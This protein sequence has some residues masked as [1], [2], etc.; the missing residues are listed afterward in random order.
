MEFGPRALGHRSIIAA[1]DRPGV[2]RKINHAIKMRDFWMP[3]APAVLAER[4]SEYV[5]NPKRQSSPFMTLSFDTTEKGRRDLAAALHPADQ[6]VRVQ[7][8]DQ[9]RAPAFHRILAAFERRTGVGGVLN[10]S[11]NIHGKPIV[12]RPVDIADEILTRD[13]VSL[14]NIYVDGTLLVRRTS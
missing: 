9:A 14:D 13:D 7:E 2:V 5:Q 1:A 11:L 4:L 12:M 6:T 8:V 3:F 10:T